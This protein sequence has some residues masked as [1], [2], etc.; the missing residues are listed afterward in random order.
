MNTSI[1]NPFI[2]KNAINTCYIDSLLMSLFYE[3][4]IIETLLDNN[5]DSTD[6]IYL[7]E[8]IKNYFI[9]NIRKNKSITEDKIN[10]IRTLIFQIGWKTDN[11]FFNQQDIKEFYKFLMNK[12]N[13]ELIEIEK[14]TKIENNYIT[15]I[16]KIPYISL[17]I[18][19]NYKSISIKQLLNEW[20]NNNYKKKINKNGEEYEINCLDRNQIINYPKM[21]AIVINRINDSIT[22]III[23]NKISPI[24]K[25]YNT[26]DWIFHSAVC[27]KNN[28]QGH[29]YSLI[30]INNTNSEFY[31]FDDLSIPCMTKIDLSDDNISSMIKRECKLLIYKR[32]Y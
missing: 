16:E 32:S 4:S 5:V 21:I 7:Q 1:I 20:T 3:K 23:Q 29:Y 30:R 12:L 13:G 31:I 27:Y 15:E 2:I 6:I 10:M 9:D 18:K 19:E 11:E 8:Y 22:D 25:L 24:N 28:K 17:D 26:T 14:T